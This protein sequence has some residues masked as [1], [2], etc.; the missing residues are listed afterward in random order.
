MIISKS[1]KKPKQFRQSKRD[2]LF[3]LIRLVNFEMG[4]VA[5]IMPNL[6]A[7]V[8]ELVL[9]SNKTLH[10]V[11]ESPGSLREIIEN[12]H[13][14]GAK[15]MPFPGRL[16]SGKYQFAGR[17][18]TLQSNTK[19]G[20]S[21]IQG[22][23]CNDYFGL[24]AL[25]STIAAHL[26]SSNITTRATRKA[27]RWGFLFASRMPSQTGLSAAQLP[28]EILTS[29]QSPWATDGIRTSRHPAIRTDCSFL[30]PL[31]ASSSLRGKKFRLAALSIRHGQQAPLRSSER[32]WIQYLTLEKNGDGQR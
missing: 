31:T 23:I 4:E 16:P 2:T 11:L 6:G 8:L 1:V 29:A 14:H 25:Q 5:T 15:L 26:L 18:Y 32:K 20:A 30:S 28:S 24:Y 13:Y 27:T 3:R 21:S 7:T 22:F 10:A 19:D 12:K 17:N 9:R